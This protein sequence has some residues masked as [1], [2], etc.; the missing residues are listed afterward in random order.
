MAAAAYLGPNKKLL[1][2]NPTYPS[3]ANYAEANGVSVVRVPLTRT[4]EHDTD[5]MNAKA[6]SATALVYIWNPNNPTGTLTP[7]KT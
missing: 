6:D 5:A 1:V 7:R 4:Q 3:L 2:P